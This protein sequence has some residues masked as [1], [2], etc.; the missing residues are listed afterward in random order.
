MAND[1][2][3]HIIFFFS[4][5]FYIRSSQPGSYLLWYFFPILNFRFISFIIF[6]YYLLVAA[7]QYKNFLTKN[8]K[9]TSFF[10]RKLNCRKSCV[11]FLQEVI[12]GRRNRWNTCFTYLISKAILQISSKKYKSFFYKMIHQ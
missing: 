7:M 4:T 5:P 12:Q 1:N 6:R 2:S 10:W 11:A 3:Y 9:N 8:S